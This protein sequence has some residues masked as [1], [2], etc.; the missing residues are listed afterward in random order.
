MSK[1]SSAPSSDFVSSSLDAR[2]PLAAQ[3]VEVD[4]LLP[5]DGHRSVRF[6]IAM[7]SSSCQS[8]PR[9]LRTAT[10]YR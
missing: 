6:Q 8:D 5:V 4:P 1:Q 2:Q 7:C 10:G 3:P 9:L